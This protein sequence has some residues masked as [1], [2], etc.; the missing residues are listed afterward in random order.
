MRTTITL[1]L[2][3]LLLIGCNSVK[4]NQKFLSQGNYDQAIELAV[5]KLQKDKKAPKN[6]EH[7]VLLEEAFKKAVAEDQR[8]ISFL[9][10]ENN[11]KS[12]RDVYYLYLDLE[13]R[14]R[15]IRP[16]L[17][18]NVPSENREAKFKFKEYTDATL[19]AKKVLGDALWSQSVRFLDSNDKMQARRAFDLLNELQ[20]LRGSD[21]GITAMI[22]DAIYIGTDFVFVTLNNR[23]GQIMPRRLEQELLDFN[24]YGLDS[25]WTEYHS[26]RD[27][28]ID[29]DY[30]IALNFRVI[31]FSPER[32][33]ERE[34]RR[35]KR[36]KDGWE[37]KKDSEGNFVLDEDGK[38]IKVDVYKTVSAMMLITEQFKAANVGGNV[39][40]RDLQRGR[41]MDEFPL[42]TEFI[43]ENVF[44]TYRGDERALSDD[45][46]I[47]MDNRFI[48]F[49]SNAQ[50]LL[51][52]S[53][54]I[55]G[56]L[57]EILRDN[58]L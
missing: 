57:K 23:S 10:K 36:V 41:D 8:R 48:P 3:T 47:L 58:R 29:Y 11:L 30:G 35:T 51:D 54:N 31:E 24:T 26:E 12:K 13:R 38:K 50:L 53:D 55:K 25:F 2:A 28:R 43:F 19:D 56:R 1:I 17:P 39:V 14:Q 21:S 42:G 40:Y 7:I 22:E 34:E 5:K 6:E 20:D 45:D 37:Y 15:W 18:L 44:A 49:P 32:I 52:A 4:R 46:L 16:L 9:K 27:Q 33:S